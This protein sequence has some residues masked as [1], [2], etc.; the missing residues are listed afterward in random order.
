MRLKSLA[1]RTYREHNLEGRIYMR[2]FGKASDAMVDGT[3]TTYTRALAANPPH[4][5]PTGFRSDSTN[6][7]FT[8]DRLDACD[9]SRAGEL[10][11]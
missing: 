11:S 3:Y 8:S 2:S 7:F 5:Q 6:G 1:A 4:M 9:L 10:A